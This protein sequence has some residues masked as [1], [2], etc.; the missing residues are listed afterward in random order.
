V[1]PSIMRGAVTALAAA[2][3]ALGGCTVRSGGDDAADTATAATHTGESG[4]TTA[5]APAPPPTPAPAPAADSTTAA[6]PTTLAPAQRPRADIRLEVDV[7]ARRLHVYRGE[8]EVATHAVAV[9]S[10]EWPTQ[11][12]E[13]V[14]AQV[15]FNPEW[16]PPDESW[17]EEREPKAPGAPDNPLG[18]AQLVYDPP[19]TIHGTD[20]PASIGKAVSHGSIRM[21]NETI[22][23]LARDVMEAAGVAKDDAWYRR[24]RENRAEKVIVDL[25]RVVPIRV[26]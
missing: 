12:G 25:P 18:R 7:A 17:A 26:R 13:W 16:I 23:A 11:T 6:D 4:G 10:K 19:R 21:R 22:T 8:Q 3:F 15:V 20:Q 14:V 5:A 24:V 9:G 2:L 1:G